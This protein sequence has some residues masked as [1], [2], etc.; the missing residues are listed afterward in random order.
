MN[1]DRINA[2]AGLTTLRGNDTLRRSN[3]RLSDPHLRPEQPTISPRLNKRLSRLFVVSLLFAGAFTVSAGDAYKWSV[4]YL[5]D[6]SRAV[7][8]RP[9]KVSPRHNR[10]LAISPDGKYLYAG[11]HHSFNN[12]G[13]VRRIRI[14]AT[15]YERATEALLPGVRAKALATDDKGRVYIADDAAIVVYDAL[16]EQRYLR[17]PFGVC[18]GVATAREGAD[19]VLYATDREAGT[20][21][22]FV[23][24]ESAATVTAATPSGFDGSG[25]LKV[26]GAFDLRGLKVDSKGN[27]WV[28]DSRGGKVFRIGS[29]GKD[30]K[31]VA[32]SGAI[33]LAIG[34][35]RIFVTRGTER[36][37]TVLD[38]EVSVL[39]TL[40]VPWE[41]LE[42]SPYGNNRNGA[43]GG[44]VAIPGKGF[45]VTNEA[46][47]TANQRSTYGRIDE[48]S[49][50]VNGKM[51]RDVF[52]DD[53]EPILHA[54]EV[55]AA[56]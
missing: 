23:M 26:A 21:T 51:Y 18:D 42:L 9:Q 27:L 16:L 47:Q 54:T 31:S 49:D 43:L 15:D 34:G 1:F 37:I 22:R 24:Q 38:E 10:G 39:G 32:V 20:I 40:N 29:G 13:E 48:H 56:P 14:D 2:D 53:N 44:I 28:A 46:G 25:S 17:I 5:I 11:Y 33:D 52:G 12:S 3:H 8:G 36:V 4:Q 41:E 7:F 6:N 55:E 50:M 19:L 35:D 45:F 30:V